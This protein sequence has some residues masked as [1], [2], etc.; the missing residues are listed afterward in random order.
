MTPPSQS[1]LNYLLVACAK[2]GDACE[3]ANLLAQGADPRSGNGTALA[4][5]VYNGHIECVKL[6]I[7]VSDTKQPNSL[8]LRLAAIH[9]HAE[10]VKL[11]IPASDSKA[12]NCIALRE[13]A[14]NGRLECFRLL[15]P[16]SA[17]LIEL[18][19]LLSEVLGC[20]RA[21]ILSIML[22]HEPR[23]LAQVDLPKSLD[24]AIAKGHSELTAL[25]RSIIEQQNLNSHLSPGNAPAQTPFRL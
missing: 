3:V 10:C 6:L 15:L 21:G 18:D 24:A 1:S 22:D 16:A 20:G 9:G 17:P 8:E 19:G 14:K 11:L 4:W 13:A 23:L 25:L 2:A 7:P 5:A 12:D